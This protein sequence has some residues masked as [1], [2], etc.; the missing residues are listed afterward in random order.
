MHVKVDLILNL[1]PPRVQ[2]IVDAITLLI[3]L[4]VFS[5]ITWQSFLEAQEVDTKSSL[6]LLSVSPFYWVLTLGF[7]LFCLAVLALLIETIVKEVRR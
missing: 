1:F 3:T 2:A 4:V 7:A 6:L 5:I